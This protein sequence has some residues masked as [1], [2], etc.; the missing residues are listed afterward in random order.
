MQPDFQSGTLIDERTP[1]QKSKDYTFEELVASA[2]LV[3]WKKKTPAEWR[4]FPKFNQDGSGSCVANTGRKMLGVYTFLKTG[5]FVELSAAH[6]Y[7]RRTNKPAG[8]MGG[9]DVFEIMRQ[10]TTLES[11]AKSEDL[12]DSQ[13]DAVSVND[14]MKEIGKAFKIGNYLTIT[15]IGD[16]ET[17]ASIIQTTGKAVMVWF[18][19]TGK[20]WG[21]SNG[22]Y[23]DYNRPQVMDVLNG[24]LDPKALRHSVAAVDYFLDENGKR[25]LVIEDTAHFGGCARRIIDE[26]F[27][28]ARNWYAAHFM[29]FA[30]EEKTVAIKNYV[31]TKTL[32]FGDN[33]PEVAELQ[34]A[35]QGLG[36]FP[37]NAQASGYYG[38][39]TAKAVLEWQKKYQV[40][41]PAELDALGGRTFGPKSI[42]RMNAIL[43]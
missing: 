24:H 10:G 19:F 5:V 32:M 37:T 25:C 34:K 17:I 30:F 43:S 35:L 21:I 2:S 11:M 13:M 3:D 20:E 4:R 16:I 1:E 15:S 7:Q 23:G 8:G 27:F 41:T 39:I 38:A 28:T 29:N 36:T 42:A 31:F 40:A 14:F 26:D 33:S 9:N 22:A 6:I 18:Y 12:S